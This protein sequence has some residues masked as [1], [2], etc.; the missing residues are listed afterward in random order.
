MASHLDFAVSY[1]RQSETY[2]FPSKIW[3]DIYNRNECEVVLRPRFFRYGQA[4]RPSP[5]VR[6]SGNGDQRAFEL[7][8]MGTKNFH[9]L[10][11]MML[12][13]GDRANCYVPVDPA[14]SPEVIQAA[15]RDGGIA[16]LHLTAHWLD[17]NA[18]IQYVVR[19]I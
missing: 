7:K 9:G 17:Q 4:L 11:I 18:I 1:Q 12:G 5:K 19:H 13:R 15:I 16:E 8:F 3:I 14:E 6:P 10:T 2:T